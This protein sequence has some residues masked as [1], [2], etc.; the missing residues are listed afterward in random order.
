VGEW[1]TMDAVTLGA[2]FGGLGLPTAVALLVPMEAGVPIPIPDDLVMLLIGERVAA[3]EFSWWIAILGLEI[4]AIAGTSLL[5]FGFRG[6]GRVVETRIGPRVG[7]T[8]DRLA[9]T[10]RFIERRGRV[11][12]VVGRLTPGLRTVTGAAAGG[13]GLS[14]R[15]ALPPLF[16]GATIFVQLHLVLGILV[17]PLARQAFEEAKGI[18]TAVGL[19]L[20]LAAAAYWF[21]RRRRVGIAGWDEAACPAC[22]GLAELSDRVVG[23]PERTSADDDASIGSR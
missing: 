8:E 15:H 5:Y 21:L 6:A 20:L 22:L 2:V 14:A 18:A 12:L 3:G 9:R 19:A 16:I 11:A 10:R 4:V 23:G 17:G 1:D 7:L 13:S